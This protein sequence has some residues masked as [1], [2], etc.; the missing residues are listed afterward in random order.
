MKINLEMDNLKKIPNRF[1]DL[2]LII[3]I[4][5]FCEQ[6]LRIPLQDFIRNS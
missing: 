5:K 4:K 3:E 2:E 6:N 1:P